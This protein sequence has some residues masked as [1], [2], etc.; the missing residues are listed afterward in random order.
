MTGLDIAHDPK[1]FHMASWRLS[2]RP[3]CPLRMCQET[4]CGPSWVQVG[5][6][7]PQLDAVPGVLREEAHYA[8]RE[9]KPLILVQPRGRSQPRAG[10]WFSVASNLSVSLSQSIWKQFTRG[11]EAKMFHWS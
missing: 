1:V 7:V 2:G 10:S 9:A 4:G 6:G 3:S 8:A 11:F 5:P